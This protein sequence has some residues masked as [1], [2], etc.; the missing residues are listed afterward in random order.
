MRKIEFGENPM[1]ELVAFRPAKRSSSSR[2]AFLERGIVVIF[3]GVR[4]E[5]IRDQECAAPKIAAGGRTRGATKRRPGKCKGKA[6]AVQ[7][8]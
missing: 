7:T 1:G 5:R 6:G 4:K 2:E 8:K 3:T